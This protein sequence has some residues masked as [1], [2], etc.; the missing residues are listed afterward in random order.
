M[1]MY[2]K[3]DARNVTEP[4]TPMTGDGLVASEYRSPMVGSDT[5][6]QAEGPTSPM[7]GGSARSVSEA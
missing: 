1:T 6:A 2:Y 4:R 7:V 5:P 3:L